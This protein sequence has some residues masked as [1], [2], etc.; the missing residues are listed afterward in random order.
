MAE[1]QEAVTL[2][3]LLMHLFNL[4]LCLYIHIFLPL[5]VQLIRWTL[6][7]YVSVVTLV[8]NSFEL[9]QSNAF[10]GTGCKPSLPVPQSGTSSSSTGHGFFSAVGSY[11][12]VLLIYVTGS[13]EQFI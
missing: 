2:L 12:L 13:L 8:E 1:R 5:M 4:K 6:L 11:A 7:Q 9:P 3:Q 10:C